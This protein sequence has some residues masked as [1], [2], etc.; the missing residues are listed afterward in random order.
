VVEVEAS[1]LNDALICC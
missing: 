1:K